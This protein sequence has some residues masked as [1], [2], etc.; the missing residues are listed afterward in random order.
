MEKQ[1]ER[2]RHLFWLRKRACIDLVEVFAEL[3]QEEPEVFRAKAGIDEEDYNDLPVQ[4]LL[5]VYDEV[6]LGLD[7]DEEDEEEEQEELED[8]LDKEDESDCD[9]AHGKD[10]EPKKS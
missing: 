7:G 6:K 3:R 2:Q 1:F 5:D 10:A 8:Q 9:E 4:E